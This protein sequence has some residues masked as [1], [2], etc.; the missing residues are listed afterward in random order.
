MICDR[1]L[2]DFEEFFLGIRGSNGEPMQELH[3]ET[4]KALESS[5]NS[6]RGADFD[7]DSLRRVDID[8]QLPGFVHWRVK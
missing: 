4:C 8:L 1:I 6:D 2:D 5:G 3:H 7:Q